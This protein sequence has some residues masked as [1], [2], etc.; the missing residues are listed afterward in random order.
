MGSS[1]RAA[2]ASL[3]SL[4]IADEAFAR[5]GVRVSNVRVDVSPLRA[6]GAHEF[7]NWVAESLPGELRRQLARHWAASGGGTVVARID[8]IQV[9]TIIARGSMSRGR[10]GTNSRSDSID[11][12]TSRAS[13]SCACSAD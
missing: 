7:A 10:G 6:S 3:A 1:R 9:G 12:P 13:L 2:L 11:G 5:T 4:I 8:A